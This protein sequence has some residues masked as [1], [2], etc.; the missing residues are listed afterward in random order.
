MATTIASLAF[1]ATGFVVVRGLADVKN[2]S[3][4][5]NVTGSARRN[6]TSDLAVWTFTLR[7]S[8]DASLQAAYRAFQAAQPTIE[9]FLRGQNFSGAELRREPVNAGPQPYTV[10]EDVNGENR[11]VQHTRYAV[12]Q[13]YRLQA[14]DIPKLQR[15]I[16]AATAAFVQVSQGGVSVETGDVEYLYTRLADVRVQLLQEASQ[17]AQRRAQAVA[18]S[19]GNTVGAVKNARV[20]VFQITP[21]FE[22]SVEDTGSYDTTSLEKDVTAVVEI[23]FVVH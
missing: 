15:A 1:L 2:A 3:D 16:G 13:T 10:I 8:D 7:S 9:A 12:S 11:E 21:R 22:T 19:A 17:D 14:T 20:G 6:I 23:D 18:R 4:V 5:I